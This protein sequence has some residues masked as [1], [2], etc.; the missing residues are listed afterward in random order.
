MS[1]RRFRSARHDA[2]RDTHWLGKGVGGPLIY[3]ALLLVA[4]SVGLLFLMG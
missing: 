3:V 1:R 2:A 4:A